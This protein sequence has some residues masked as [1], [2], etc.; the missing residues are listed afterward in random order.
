MDAKRQ[1]GDRKFQQQVMSDMNQHVHH[2]ATDE[3]DITTTK[4]YMQ[5]RTVH[6]PC[7]QHAWTYM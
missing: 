2:G 1:M 7:Q 6:V 3:V 4:D 5:V